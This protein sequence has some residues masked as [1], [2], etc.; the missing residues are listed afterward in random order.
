MEIMIASP[1]IRNLIREGKA[2]QITGTIQTSVSMGMQTMDQSLRDLFRAGL[3]T[4][5]EAVSRAMNPEEFKAMASGSGGGPG[6][7]PGMPGGP[8]RR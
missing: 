8:A 5:D 1:A 2:H 7:R 6:G 3:I 4:Y